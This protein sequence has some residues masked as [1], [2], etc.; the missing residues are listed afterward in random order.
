MS[1]IDY[2]IAANNA[3]GTLGQTLESLRAQTLL[4]WRAIVID[5]ASDDG[6]LGVALAFGDD[7]VDA[8]RQ[9]RGGP[10]RAR[11]RGLALTRSPLVCFLDA[12]DLVE[13][14]HA[15]GLTRAIGA[16]D[17]VACGYRFVGAGGEDLGWEVHVS[18]ED[19]ALPRLL[20]FNALATGGVVFR[21][22]AVERVR[23]YD[24]VCEHEDWDLLLRLAREGASWAR[25]VREPLFR[26]RLGPA[27]RTTRLEAQWRDG[28]AVIG[29]H[30]RDAEER[31]RASRRWSLRALAR[32]MAHADGAL[33]AR[34]R[35]EVFPL[36]ES[37]M[38]VLSGALAWAFPRA[39]GISPRRAGPRV[40]SWLARV[41][42]ELGVETGAV[43]TALARAWIDWD[44]VARAAR[45][46]LADGQ[47]LVLLGMGRNGLALGAALDALGVSYGWI[48]DAGGAGGMEWGV[49]TREHAVIVT[50]AERA[51]ILARLSVT[52]VGAVWL[53]EDL[54]GATLR[55]P[56]PRAIGGQGPLAQA[57]IGQHGR[58]REGS[59]F[60]RRTA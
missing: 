52:S 60:G 48:D 39:E 27:S 2:I 29:R 21:R 34:L 22:A 26:Y 11:N 51:S 19:A 10:G 44:S 20:E 45:D 57:T 59:A 47:R 24:G 12:D 31:A 30:A 3:A 46:R 14:T 53:P 41:R 50:P 23:G 25:P 6:T 55:A 1:E 35:G 58:G 13:P 32:A 7:R 5:D 36:T 38:G 49:L 40:E 8:A 54:T 56:S 15:E 37:D 9:P 18:V 42:S 16:C 43:A 33:L 17:A 4:T 28:L